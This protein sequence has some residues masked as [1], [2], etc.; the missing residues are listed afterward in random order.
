MSPDL[1]TAAARETKV[2]KFLSNTLLLF[3]FILV[4]KQLPSVVVFRAKEPRAAYLHIVLSRPRVVKAGL[5]LSTP[6]CL[7]HPLR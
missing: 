5:I 3:L 6:K 1:R 4:R 2:R 7:P